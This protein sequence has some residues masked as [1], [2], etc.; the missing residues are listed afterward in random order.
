MPDN[1][2]LETKLLSWLATQ[3]YP[4]EMTVARAFQRSGFRVV[5]S[6]YYTKEGSGISREIDVLA[7]LQKVEEG[8][9]IR[10]TIVVECKSSKEKPWLLFSKERSLAKPA[11]IAQRAASELGT[12]VLH[13][14]AS[15][16][17]IQDLP[18][19]SIPETPAYG[20]TQAFT[21]GSDVCYA[22][23]TAVAE[24]TAGIADDASARHKRGPYD[25]LEIFLPVIV[26]DARIF[27]ATLDQE[28]AVVINEV[29]S[30]VLLW[31]NPIVGMPHTII[32]VVSVGALDAFAAS[33]MESAKRLLHALIETHR[34]TV[35]EARERLRFPGRFRTL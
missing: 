24:A 30:G 20:L 3:G 12:H 9:V 28:A 25:I 4:L 18:I 8:L 13:R 15:D 16:E 21:S 34:G 14:I 31:R 1:S 2:A 26:T 19:F 5:Q 27:S 6:D 33:S 7:S 11:L 35:D 32:N 23:A 17:R 29:P 22:A 10:V